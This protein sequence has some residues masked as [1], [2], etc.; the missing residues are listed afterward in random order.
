MFK[1]I[2]VALIGFGVG[3][4]TAQAVEVR[5]GR[6][7]V[8]QLS[9][10][11]RLGF[12]PVEFPKDA[13]GMTILITGPEGYEAMVLSG[14]RLPELDLA[15]FGKV[16]DG[17]YLYEI[18]GAFGEPI[19]LEVVLD[20]GRDKDEPTAFRVNSFSL[21]GKLVVREGKIVEFEQMQEKGSEEVIP[22]KEVDDIDPGTKATPPDTE[23]RPR[24]TEDKDTDKG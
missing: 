6:I 22:E 15:E 12:R 13:R 4:G 1:A 2:A 10:G 7:I 8:D 9:E 18:T 14:K 24:E 20:N 3:I 11:T 23:R 21:T 17:L 5:D 16:L 19:K